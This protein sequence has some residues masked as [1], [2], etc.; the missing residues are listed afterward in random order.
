[1]ATV[2]VSARNFEEPPRVDLQVLLDESDYFSI[3]RRDPDRARTVR[4]AELLSCEAG[5]VVAI[6]DYESPFATPVVY[7]VISSSNV[8]LAQS[9][10]VRLDPPIIDYA[11]AGTTQLTAVWLRHLTIPR[12]SMPIDLTNVETPTLAQTRTVESVI[13]RPDPIVLTDGRRKSPTSTIDI[14]TWT[15]DERDRLL[16]LLGDNSTLLLT[17]PAEVGWG[18]TSCYVT[19]GDVSEERLWQ[20]WAPFAGRVFHLPVEYGDAPVGGRMDLGCTYRSV[21]EQAVCYVDF[22]G[23]FGSYALL[24]SCGGGVTPDPDAPDPTLVDDA[25][26]TNNLGQFGSIATTST[27]ETKT[28]PT[29]SGQF[30]LTHQSYPFV[31]VSATATFFAAHTYQFVGSVLYVSPDGGGTITQTLRAVPG[32]EPDT[33]GGYV[34][35]VQTRTVANGDYVNIYYGGSGAWPTWS[36]PDDGEYTITAYLTGTGTF[37]TGSPGYSPYTLTFDVYTPGSTTSTVTPGAAITHRSYPTLTA[38][39]TYRIDAQEVIGAGDA[40]AH[41]A[42]KWAVGTVSDDTMKASANQIGGALPIG[43]NATYTVSPGTDSFLADQDGVYEFAL[44]AYSDGIFTDGTDSSNP[45]FIRV[46]EVS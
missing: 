10:S 27:A 13:G 24:G 12:R 32:D 42:L 37:S 35:D 26:A 7:Q 5:G 11:V 34:I 33:S 29:H 22:D 3:T 39:T 19:V 15:L 28:S 31:L 25:T 45:R 17:V 43:A 16:R 41:L 20:E 38:G 9:P 2:L 36:P 8:V 21:A 18:V 14:R 30:S 23:L 44:Y 46:Y 1:M 4:G 40:P 6:S